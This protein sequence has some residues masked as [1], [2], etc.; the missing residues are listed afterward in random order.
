[1][2]VEWWENMHSPSPQELIAQ[3][4][5]V[6]NVGWWPLYYVTGGPLAGL[7][8]TEQDFYEQ[9]SP[10]HFEGPYTARWLGGP[11]QF[12]ELDPNEPGQLGATLAV[13]NDD[14]NAMTEQQIAAGIAPRLAILAQKT[15]G[16]TPRH[17]DYAG[18]AR[19]AEAMTR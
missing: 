18:F 11:P 5:P 16:T 1:V 2:A 7:R 17:A 13:W 9:W 19:D 4:H 3:G 6:L 10:E 14:P 8:S 15:W 12:Y